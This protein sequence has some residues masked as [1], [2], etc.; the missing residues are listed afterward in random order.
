M[1]HRPGV[2]T[3]RARW[4]VAGQRAPF[5][6]TAGPR[7]LPSPPPRFTVQVALARVL[8]LLSPPSRPAARAADLSGGDD[9]D[10]FFTP[11]H[12]EVPTPGAGRRRLTVEAQ[13]AVAAQLGCFA[14]LRGAAP[15]LRYAGLTC[16]AV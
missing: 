4:G 10:E 6:P 15:A 9:G 14:G 13:P 3:S 16:L 12:S 2:L 7:P 1:G 8:C 11:K 5:H